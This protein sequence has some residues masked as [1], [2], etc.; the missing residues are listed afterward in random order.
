LINPACGDY[1][2]ISAVHD[3]VCI[4]CFQFTPKGNDDLPDSRAVGALQKNKTTR[5][6]EI[7]DGTSNTILI[8]EDA[9]RPQLYNQQRIQSSSATEGGWAAP[10]ASFSIDGSN[11]DGTIHGSCAINCSNDSELYSFHNG[12]AHLAFAD[13]SVRFMF[14]DAL[15]QDQLLCLIA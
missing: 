10:G 5:F 4:N 15:P 13:G 6:I 14:S 3:P 11:P 1:S 12:G 8:A 2:C 7:Q 9:G